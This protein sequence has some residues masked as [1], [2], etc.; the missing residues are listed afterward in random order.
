MAAAASW[1]STWITRRR[2]SSSPATIPIR[3][4][5]SSSAS[6][7]NRFARS[8]RNG[9]DA[10][11]GG[12]TRPKIQMAGALAGLK[13]VEI[14]EMVSA[15]YTAKLM[16]DMGAEVIKVERPGIGD[17][18]RSR[19]PFPGDAPHPEKS[20]LFL[21]LNTNKF[22]VT[23]DISRPEGFAILERMVAQADV[24]I[25]NVWPPYMDRVGLNYERFRKLNPRLVMTSVEPFGLSGAHRNWRAEE[26]TMWSAGGTCVLNGGGPEHPEMPPL[27]T[28]GNQAGF[29]GGVHAAVATMGAVFAQLHDGE[30]QHVEVSVQESLTGIL[31]LTFE[32]GPYMRMIASRLGRKPIQPMESMQ[33]KDG[34]IF[35]CCVEE[36]QWQNF[37]H[38]MGDPEWAGEDIFSDRLKR[39]R[40]GRRSGFFSRNGSASRPYSISTK[41]YRRGGS[42]SHRSRRWATCSAPSI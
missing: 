40:T 23:L 14:G 6:K 35:L 30:G 11:Q 13:I 27:K 9:T 2:R 8:F 19:G 5:V 39:E 33:C 17:R 37:V 18:A 38:V 41:R 3:S 26:L 42:R 22:G 32:F 31:E 7:S 16:A 24:L 10:G 20:G 34:W 15:P 36:H 21:Y 4:R 1:W 25:H 29:Q 28:F 12:T